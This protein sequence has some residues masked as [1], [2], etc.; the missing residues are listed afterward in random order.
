M[1]GR[2][3]WLFFGDAEAGEHS[4]IIY[5][6]I[7]SCRRRGLDPFSYLRDVLTRLP[8]M[9]NRQIPEIMQA[10]WAKSQAAQLQKAA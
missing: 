7:E 1:L 5:T 9:T 2:R 6:V 4:A 3:N 8:N 10:A